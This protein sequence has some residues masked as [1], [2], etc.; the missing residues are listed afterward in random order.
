MSKQPKFGLISA[1]AIRPKLIPM[2]QTFLEFFLAVYPTTVE[3]PHSPEEE[4]C[5]T[6]ILAESWGSLMT[7]PLPLRGFE[8]LH[9]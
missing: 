1:K 9:F 6:V 8:I 4:S 5:A 3:S 2:F 7:S